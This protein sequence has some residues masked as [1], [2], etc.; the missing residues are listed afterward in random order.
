MKQI[1]ERELLQ[2]SIHEAGH[3]AVLQALGGHGFIRIHDAG[4]SADEKRWQGHTVIVRQPHKLRRADIYVGLAGVVAEHIYAGA[5]T[6]GQLDIW[7]FFDPD[8]PEEIS[9][10]D[11]P[12]FKSATRRDLAFTHRCL[13][14]NWEE[15][16]QKAGNEIRKAKEIEDE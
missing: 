4:S 7:A 10:T 13:I 11:M 1:Y 3:L 9:V 12:A 5:V 14:E 15:V 2:T 8:F 16:L 6:F